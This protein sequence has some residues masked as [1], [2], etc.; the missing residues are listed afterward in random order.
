MLQFRGLQ[1]V[2]HDL[3]TEQQRQAR[4]LQLTQLLYLTCNLFSLLIF[5]NQ[6]KVTYIHQRFSL[7]IAFKSE[8]WMVSL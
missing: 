1:R 2:R 8:K 4:F 7:L 6:D 5:Q 3:V